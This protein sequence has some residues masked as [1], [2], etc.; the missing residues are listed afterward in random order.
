MSANERRPLTG[1]ELYE[2]HKALVEAGASLAF[3]IGWL[4]REVDLWP[5]RGTQREDERGA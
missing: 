5:E 1:R 2:Q 3:R 4:R